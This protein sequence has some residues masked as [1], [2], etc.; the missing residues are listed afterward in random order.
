MNKFIPNMYQKDIYSIDFKKLKQLGIKILLFDFDNTIIEKGNY[1]ISE[2]AIKLFKDLKK[3]FTVYIVSNSFNS[4]KLKT[5]CEQAS[6]DYVLAAR[7]PFKSGFNKLNLS[8]SKEVAMVGDQV[9]TDVFGGNRM[10]YFTVL[11]DP[12]TSNELIF[13]KI[14]RI[15]ENMIL[16]INKIKR[17]SYYD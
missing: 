16:K 12:I 5:I 2:K 15:F 8:N 10:N 1:E 14:N 9:I 6:L 4:N 11:I 7:K 3:D 13:T 17:G